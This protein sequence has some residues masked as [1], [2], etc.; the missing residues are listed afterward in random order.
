[1]YNRKLKTVFILVSVSIFVASLFSV[2]VGKY[3][4]T[5]GE[6]KDLIIGNPINDMSSKVFF[7]LRLPRTI[8]ALVSGFGLGMAGSIYQTIFKNPLASPDI[9]GVSSGA[10]LGAAVAIVII[11]NQ[12]SFVAGSA[13]IGGIIAVLA[14]TS[15]VYVSRSNN[16]ASYVLA[17]IVISSLSQSIIKVLKFFADPES[18][19]AS[20]EFW[21]MGSFGSV[22]SSKLLVV[23]PIILLGIMALILLRRQISLLALNE[24]ESRMLG[25]RV[26]LVRILILSLT[27]LVVSSIISITGLIA[28][29]GLIAPHISKLLLKR[30]N[31]TT[32]ILSGCIGS[33][34][35][36]LADCLARILYST[37]LPISILTTFLGVPFLVY[38]MYSRKE[39]QI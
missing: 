3:P 32:C 4:I 22:T 26:T 15:L 10:N 35:I 6:I 29:I 16:T 36:V 2:C 5:L 17:G 14:V 33:L 7:N 37:E 24:D 30:Q 31:F 12:I 34:I 11:G 21:S 1:M 8:M 19:L 38:F 20:I 13:F 39:K 9:I 28:F 18:E 27:T 23:L 25:V